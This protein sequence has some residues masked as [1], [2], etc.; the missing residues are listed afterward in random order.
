M[1]RKGFVSIPRNYLFLSWFR[2]KE[3]DRLVLAGILL[4]GFILVKTVKLCVFDPFGTYCII[5]SLLIKPLAE[6]FFLSIRD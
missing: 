5:I 2:S 4:V 1:F 6:Y 3:L